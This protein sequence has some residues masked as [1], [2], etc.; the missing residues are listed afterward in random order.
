M[1]ECAPGWVLPMNL[2]SCRTESCAGRVSEW[3]NDSPVCLQRLT[4]YTRA[5][6]DSFYKFFSFF[7]IHLMLLSLSYLI[8]IWLSFQNMVIFVITISLKQM[9]CNSF[10]KTKRKT[11]I[12]YTHMGCG[13]SV[14]LSSHLVLLEGLGAIMS[15][16]WSPLMRTKGVPWTVCQRAS[17]RVFHTSL[18][19]KR[20]KL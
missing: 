14:S 9:H 4:L 13:S 1:G 12:A 2:A 16:Q 8:N 5:M 3:E 18:K 19:K 20:S 6:L 11:T 15:R 7:N 17:L 10:T